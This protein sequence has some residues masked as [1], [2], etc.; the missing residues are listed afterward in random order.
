MKRAER[1]H[2]KENE[3]ASLALSVKEAFVTRR[4]Q[5]IGTLVVVVAVV[6]ALV[7]YVAWRG[8]IQARADTLLAEALSLEEARVGPP[9]LPGTPSTGLSFATERERQQAMQSKFKAVADEFPSTA[10]GIFARYREGA[11]LVA[12]GSPAEAVKAYQQAVDRGGDSLYGQMARLGLA[13]AQAR[14]GE[15]DRAIETFQ[16][17][18]Q[19]AEGPLPV[20]GLLMQL[21]RTYLEAGKPAEA[22]QTFNRIV[23]E[24]PNS[25]FSGEA[26][27][28]LDS[29]NET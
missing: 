27:R 14:A 2:L 8:R 7:G 17:L 13:E 20:D 23:E 6:G 18:T 25:P 28:Q 10:A 4:V 24:F 29:L 26:R 16:G 11:S 5:S 1:H 21:G 19:G 15:Y 3:F 12:L 9:P 22:Q